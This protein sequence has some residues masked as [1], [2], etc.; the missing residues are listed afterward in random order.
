MKGAS[1]IAADLSVPERVL[2][3]CIAS[4]T[5]WERAGITGAVVTFM[6]VRGLVQRDPVGRLSLTKEGRAVFQALIGRRP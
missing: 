3:F 6:I 2:L 1:N 5:E 4:G